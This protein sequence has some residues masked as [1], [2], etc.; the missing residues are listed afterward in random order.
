[1]QKK[2]VGF[3]EPMVKITIIA[4]V[5]FIFLYGNKRILGMQLNNYYKIFLWALAK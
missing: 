5:K 2:T 3:L 4:V 1:M